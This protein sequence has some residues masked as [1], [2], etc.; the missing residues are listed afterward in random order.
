MINRL[1]V[2]FKNG[3]IVRVPFDVTEFES[4]EGDYRDF[5][6]GHLIGFNSKKD[7]CIIRFL[8]SDMGKEI[9]EEREIEI[10]SIR[11]C[12]LPEGIKVRLADQNKGTILALCPKDY[13]DLLSRYYVLTGDVITIIP[14]S[15]IRFNSHFQSPYPLDQLM[16]YELHNPIWKAR[17]DKI[18][19]NYRELQNTTFGIEALVGTRVQLLAHQAEVIAEVLSNNIC[20][21]VL[22]DEVGLG[23]T[24]EACVI[25]KSLKQREKVRALIIAPLSLI[26]QW[27]NELD[28]KFWLSFQV[29]DTQPKSMPKSDDTIISS[30]LLADS[31][32]L[33]KWVVMQSWQMLIVDEAHRARL[34]SALYDTLIVLSELSHH[35]LLLSATPIQRETHEYIALLKLLDPIQ[36]D[37]LN[38]EIFDRMLSAQQRIREVTAYIARGLIIGQFDA[39]DFRDEIEVIVKE[40]EHDLKLRELVNAVKTNSDLE[41]AKDVIAYISTNYRLEAQ[42]IRNRR[43]TLRDRE[44]VILPERIFSSDYTY[45]LT[46]SEQQVLQ[47]LHRYADIYRAQIDYFAIVQNLFHAAASSPDALLSLVRLKQSPSNLQSFLPDEKEVLEELIWQAE[48]WQNETN[49]SLDRLPRQI[50][51]NEPHRFAQVIRALDERVGRN[52]NKVVIFSHW[53]PTIE[54]ITKRLELRYGRTSIA[55]FMVGMTSEELQSQV[56]RFQSEATCLILI[57]DESGGEGRNFQIAQSIIHID[58][59]WTPSQ[60]EQRIGR[61]DRLG[62]KGEVQSIVPFGI[63]TLESDLIALWQGAFN[64]FSQSMSGLEIVLE[65]VQNEIATAFIKDSREGLADL[66]EKMLQQASELRA[67]IEEERYYEEAAS[68]VVWS[69]QLRQLLQRYNSGDLLGEPILSWASLAGLNHHFNPETRIVRIGRNDFNPKSIINAKFVNPPN[70]QEALQ[71]SGRPNNQSLVGTFDRQIAVQREDLI[72]FAPGEPWTE[73]ILQ[74]AILSDRGRCCAIGRKSKLLP[75]SWYGFEYLF[76]CR[77]NPRAMFIEGLLPIHLFKAGEFFTISAT[78]KM[79]VSFDGTIMSYNSLQ[80]QL[81]Q[82]EYRKNQDKHLGQRG[83]VQPHLAEIKSR[84]GLQEWHE[85]IQIS[86]DAAQA[87]LDNSYVDLIREDAETAR[88]TLDQRI[89]GQVAALAWL[90]DEQRAYRQEQVNLMQRVN[91]ALIQGILETEWVLESACFWMLEHEDEN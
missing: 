83:G 62:R 91:Q 34:N 82:A 49:L 69:R 56:D 21:Y 10:G 90:P 40:L 76:S 4:Y 65:N 26:R 45:N 84:F 16:D 13:G 37:R 59:P 1:N 18:I 78:H 29:I 35:V 86:F 67:A 3:M 52:K 61:V 42:I 43:K 6:S 17:R 25:L 60:I 2:D 73:T 9:Y 53:K 48:Q 77:F 38:D 30:E 5:R 68:N 81:V 87:H 75:E 79:L 71:R 58:I 63:N 14:E 72:F 44:L 89:R 41:K 70:M 36:Y 11:R 85:G 46:N 7:N 47:T 54:Y 27:Q 15:E 31:Q 23:K 64:L 22:A 32:Y 88:Y 74:N 57:T 33:Q 39:E 55:R 20:R 80:A 19:E 8:H 24:I 51:K 66:Y 50:P 12:V 28:S